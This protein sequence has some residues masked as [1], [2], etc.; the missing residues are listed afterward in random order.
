MNKRKMVNEWC[1]V[2]ELIN[3]GRHAMIMNTVKNSTER[4]NKFLAMSK[5]PVLVD[6]SCSYLLMFLPCV[7]C[8]VS[9]DS[10]LAI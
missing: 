10:F 2:H 3:L 1:G 4:L 8:S 5:P 9:C 6:K 7:A